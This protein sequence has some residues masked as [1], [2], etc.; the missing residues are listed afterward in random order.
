MKTGFSV[1]IICSSVN[2]TWFA[3]SSHQKFHD[4]L[5][6]KPGALWLFTNLNSLKA[7]NFCEIKRN[8]AINQCQTMQSLH[9]WKKIQQKNYFAFSKKVR[10]IY[11]MTLLCNIYLH[12]K[13]DHNWSKV[14]VKL[15]NSIL[16]HIS[17]RDNFSVS[18]QMKK[19]EFCLFVQIS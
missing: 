13:T 2:F 1:H 14:W 12:Y 4:T 17:C 6:F 19:K 3:L 18:V 7:N 9:S 15:S 8:F 5:Q 10:H 16:I 11:W